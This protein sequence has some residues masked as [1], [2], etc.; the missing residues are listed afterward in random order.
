MI[1]KYIKRELGNIVEVVEYVRTG[2]I[3]HRTL[4]KNGIPVDIINR[5]HL[6][7]LAHRLFMQN[8]FKLSFLTH[9]FLVVVSLG[10]AR[11]R[12]RNMSP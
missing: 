1:R 10:R 4:D 2:K 7:V 9:I 5:P 8:P 11:V 6:R 3:V 12:L